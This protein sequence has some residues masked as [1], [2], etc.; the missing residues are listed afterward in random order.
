MVDQLP[1]PLDEIADVAG[2]DAALAI[3]DSVGGTRVSLPARARPD[4]WLTVCVGMDKAKLICDHFRTL[5]PDDD[6]ERGVPAIVIPRGPAT[7]MAKAKARFHDA[8]QRGYS[9]REAA[10]IAKVHEVTAW[11]W[12]KSLAVGETNRDQLFLFD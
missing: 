3:A 8:R 1:Y 12:E 7:L 11:R 2:I 5:S 9:V 4:H 6:R 10:R